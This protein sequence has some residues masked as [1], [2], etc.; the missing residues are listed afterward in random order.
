MTLDGSLMAY[1]SI[2]ILPLAVVEGPLV[3]I[4]AGLLS[5]QGFLDWPWA[6]A[7]LV[8]GDV[9]G[10]LLYYWVGRTGKPGLTRL[11]GRL[12]MRSTVSPD[13][14]RHLTDH[15]AKMLCIGKWTQSLGVVVLVG[16]GMLRVPLAKFVLVNL[17]ATLPKSG[18]LFGIGW[19][20]GNHLG[21]LEAH[22]MATA[23]AL[24]AV[25]AAAILLV[26]RRARS[27]QAGSTGQ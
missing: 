13:L 12:G 9:L 7:M 10:D 25:G 3:S 27:I 21:Q 11:L 2:L 19:F 24:G 26:L 18:V 5:A 22:A 8:L 17:M 16:S 15:A 23:V 20:A 4:A 14:Q 1:G 6:L